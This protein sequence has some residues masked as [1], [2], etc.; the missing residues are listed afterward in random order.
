[1]HTLNVDE[2]KE[3]QL[4]ILK[5]VDAW[6]KE[7]HVQYFLAYGTLLGAVRHQGY[8]PWDDDIDLMMLRPDYEKMLREFNQN[9]TDTLQILHTSVDPSYPY[10]FAKV[11]DT[12]TQMLEETGIPYKIGI[13]IDIF[14]MDAIQN[15]P[16]AVPAIVK[17]QKLTIRVLGWKIY[18]YQPEKHRLLKRIVSGAVHRAASVVSL[19]SLMERMDQSAQKWGDVGQANW[20]GCVCQRWFTPGEVLEAEW[21]HDAVMLPFEGTNFPVP[22][23]YDRVLTSWFGDYM[24]FPPAEEQVTHHSFTAY[25][26]DKV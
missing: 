20:V 11:H 7:N 16:E 1:M 6:C 26:K 5:Q 24:Q 23:Q 3:Y 21:L 10:E 14:P 22:V 17:K 25:A 15:G 2:L 12:A 9:R 19:H 13:N 18:K 4:A 8:I